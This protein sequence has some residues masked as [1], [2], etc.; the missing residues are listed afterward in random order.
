MHTAVAIQ[1]ALAY[2]RAHGEGQF[3]EVAQLELGAC[4]SAEQIIDFAM[5]QR[6]QQRSGNRARECAPQGVYPCKEDQ[7]LAIAAREQREWKALVVALGRPAWA[8]A[9]EFASAEGRL[10][11][12]DA[13]DR[14]IERWTREQDADEAAER[15]RESGVPAATVLSPADLYG[16]RQLEARD[17]YQTI[18]HPVSGERRYP[19]WPM[20]FSFLPKEVHRR[21][22][23]T[24]GRDNE[25]ILCGELGVS[26]D[27]FAEL[28]RRGIIGDRLPK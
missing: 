15:L 10:S 12:A 24:L 7:W 20:R 3:I 19:V 21:G 8:R 5:N 25:E 6:I 13:I 22:A 27:R 4:L 9:S 1:A 26:A 18:D 14:E 16:E 2:R 23:P 28:V 11:A 17:Y